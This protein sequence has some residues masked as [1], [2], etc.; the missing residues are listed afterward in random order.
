L[1]LISTKTGTLNAQTLAPGLHK[2]TGA[3]LV[4]SDLTFQGSQ[5]DSKFPPELRPDSSLTASTIAWILQIAGTLNIGASKRVIL[6]GG[7]LPANI[8]WVVS[9]AVTLAAGAHIEGIVL[10]AS[11]ITLA[12]G[13]SINGRLLS[14]TSVALQKAVVTQP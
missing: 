12:T 5:T 7:A 1:S 8:V 14:Q 4:P 10:S 11:S 6:L 13:A 3:V 2:W 9:G